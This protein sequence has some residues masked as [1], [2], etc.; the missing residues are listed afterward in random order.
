VG[1]GHA[2][3]VVIASEHF[4]SSRDERGLDAALS[5]LGS[6]LGDDVFEHWVQEVNITPQARANPLR[7]VGEQSGWLPL[8][9]QELADSV[10]AAV[11]GIRGGLPEH[12]CHVD[13]ERA[14]WAMFELGQDGEPSEQ[15]QHPDIF[16]ATSMRPEMLRCHLSGSHFHSPRFS[17]HGEVFCGLRYTP[18]EAEMNARADRRIEVEMQLD[19]ALVPGRLGCVVGSGMGTRYVYVYLA[20]QQLEPALQLAGRRLRDLDLPKDARFFFLDS[21]WRHEW[22]GV[23]GAEAAPG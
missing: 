14:E 13:C 2:L 11:R 6:L 16:V 15:V 7:L 5:L 21:A 19:R 18:T 23:W 9:L 3:D 22:L 10:E 17:A 20:L 4:A 12:P 1:R 8:A